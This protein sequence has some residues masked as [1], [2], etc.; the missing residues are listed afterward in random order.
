MP[1]SK[2]FNFCSLA[3][4]LLCTSA[5]SALGN[6]RG[7]CASST[8]RNISPFEVDVANRLLNGTQVYITANVAD[9][10]QVS[11]AQLRMEAAA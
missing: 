7:A 11:L 8:T 6:F 5:S 4:L 9:T 10:V 1:R 3:S 2:T